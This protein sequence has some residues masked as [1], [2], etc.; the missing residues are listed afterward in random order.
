M[1]EGADVS[2]SDRNKTLLT[3]TCEEDV[4]VWLNI[5]KS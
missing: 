3:Y 4:G 1:Y 5:D 2:Q